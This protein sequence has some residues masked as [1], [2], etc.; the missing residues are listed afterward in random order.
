M[1][2]ERFRKWRSQTE[3]GEAL[4]LAD[5]R[6][7]NEAWYAVWTQSHY[8][9]IVSQ[10]LSAK[11]FAAFLPQMSVWS[12]REGEMRLIRV[13]MFP[14]YLFVRD[15]MEKRSYIEILKAR[16]VVRI[17][18]DGW[19]RLTPIPDV[20]IDAIQ[21]VVSADVPVL[22]HAHLSHGDRVEVVAGPLTGI[23]GIFEQDKPTKGRLV[24]NVDL[25]GRSVAVEVDCTAVR[26][27]GSPSAR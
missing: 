26:A 2:R 10:Q 27:C 15:S 25:L 16:G 4:A 18:E 6:I 14:G 12:K 20:D 8:E 13:P 24:L 22:P 11:G 9:Q 23:C 19:T 3:G 21:Q 17:L 5:T 1:G 7:G